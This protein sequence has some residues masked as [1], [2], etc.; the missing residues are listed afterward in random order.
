MLRKL[1][2]KVRPP[3]LEKVA[4]R[5]GAFAS[6]H[7]PAGRALLFAGGFALVVMLIHREVYGFLTRRGSYAVPD[8]QT[9]VAPAWT[10]RQGEEIVKIANPGATL[11]DEAL[12]AKVGKAFED[13]AWIRRVT[14]VERLFPDQLRIRFEY[15][16]ARVAVRCENGY[17][18]VDADGVR[19]P[20]V[21]VE[22]PACERSTRV[23]GVGTRPPEPGKVWDHAALKAGM[24]MADYVESTALLSRLKVREVNV[25]NHGGRLDPRLSE[26]T[27]LTSSG[28][29]LAWGRTPDTSRFGDPSPEEKLENLR[30]VLAAYPE[31]SGVRRVKIHFRGARAVEPTEGHA[32]NRR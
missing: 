25:A 9:A 12:V 15:R 10:D 20:G 26:V 23:A 32:N 18:L 6:R 8:I 22:P 1:L 5:V 7:R 16:T 31:L 13:C 21:Y 27:L 30:E 11:F 28:V 17:V 29:E 3:D 19:L 2:K 14:A 4:A 24:A